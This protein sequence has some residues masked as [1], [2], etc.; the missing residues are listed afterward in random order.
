MIISDYFSIEKIKLLFQ[1]KARE[2]RKKTPVLARH[3]SANEIGTTLTTY[4]YDAN[5]LLGCKAETECISS[6]DMVIVRNMTELRDSK[7]NPLQDNENKPI[8]NEYAM[9]I[10]TFKKNYGHLDQ[11]SKNFKHKFYKKSL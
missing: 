10:T 7:G 5:N 11:L 6:K 3:V 1:K 2:Y 8:Y 4:I 9:P